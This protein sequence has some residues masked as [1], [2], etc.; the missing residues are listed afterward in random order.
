MLLHA[1]RNL[2]PAGQGV[3]HQ[4]KVEPTGILALVARL[5]CRV[6]PSGTAP[7]AWHHSSEVPLH[8]SNKPGPMERRVMHVL[9][10]MGQLFF[11]CPDAQEAEWRRVVRT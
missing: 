8:K 6:L 5:L 1:P 9:P 3:G 11:K 10:S 4:T 7:L 2:S